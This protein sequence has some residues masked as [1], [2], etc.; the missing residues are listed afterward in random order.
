M[1]GI[2]VPHIAEFLD[3]GKY[4]DIQIIIN[5]VK[6]IEE[7]RLTKIVDDL[8]QTSYPYTRSNVIDIYN[9]THIK[10]IHKYI[11]WRHQLVFHENGDNKIKR[12]GSTHKLVIE[13]SEEIAFHNDWWPM[14]VA[15]LTASPISFRLEGRW[16]FV[17]YD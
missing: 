4:I 5:D 15:A 1:A 9:Y 11:P 3:S 6:D 12:K 13:T 17:K 16:K 7:G 8:I 14:G 10:D 2:F